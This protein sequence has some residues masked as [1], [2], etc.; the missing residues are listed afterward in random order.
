MR[1]DPPDSARCPHCDAPT[2]LKPR[3]QS[4]AER[5]RSVATDLGGDLMVK[6]PSALGD[7]EGRL[8]AMANELEELIK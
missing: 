8:L 1:T 3:L 7:H 5:L 6:L 4:L 2:A